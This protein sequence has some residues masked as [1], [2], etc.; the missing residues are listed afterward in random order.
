MKKP[1]VPEEVAK[2]QYDYIN[3]YKR[4]HYKRINFELRKDLFEDTLI[5]AAKEKNMGINSYIR[6]AIEEKL[7]RETAY[8]RK[9]K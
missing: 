9:E 5:P 3:Q 8:K 2:R 7:E 6:E 1:G 4:T